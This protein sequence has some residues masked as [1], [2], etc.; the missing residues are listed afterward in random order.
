MRRLGPP[1]ADLLCL[2]ALD[3]LTDIDPNRNASVVQQLVTPP[4]VKVGSGNVAAERLPVPSSSGH[5]HLDD[6]NG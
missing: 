2:G 3:S 4:G 1:S 5:E 6:S